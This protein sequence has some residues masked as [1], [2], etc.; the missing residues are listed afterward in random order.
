MFQFGKLLMYLQILL[1]NIGKWTTIWLLSRE[2]ILYECYN[3][4]GAGEFGKTLIKHM[5]NLRIMIL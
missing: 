5:S 3:F 2:A 1:R 4:K